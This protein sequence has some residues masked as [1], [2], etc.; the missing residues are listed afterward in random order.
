MNLDR[1]HHRVNHN[2]DSLRESTEDTMSEKDEIDVVASSLQC[3]PADMGADVVTERFSFQP[4][5]IIRHAQAFEFI[6]PLRRV[7]KEN[8]IPE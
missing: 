8:T 4:S 5:P 6:P 3:L 2:H 7:E 1:S